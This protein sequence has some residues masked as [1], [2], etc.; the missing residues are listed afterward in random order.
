MGHFCGENN[1]S[2]VLLFNRHHIVMA[3]AFRHYVAKCLLTLFASVFKLL[4][5][6]SDLAAV[7]TG[8]ALVDT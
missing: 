4:E 3:I 1:L 6:H 5:L 7:Y 2:I 8:E